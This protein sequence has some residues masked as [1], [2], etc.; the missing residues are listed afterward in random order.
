MQIEIDEVTN[1]LEHATTDEAVQQVLS[2]LREITK[3]KNPHYWFP[4]EKDR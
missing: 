3:L 4:N 1:N 2:I